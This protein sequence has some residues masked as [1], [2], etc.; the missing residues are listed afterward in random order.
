MST[1]YCSA[2]PCRIIAR[3]GS[4]R[5]AHLEGWRDFRD[6][7]TKRSTR[8]HLVSADEC[9][10]AARRAMFD[11]TPGVLLLS[12]TLLG[13]GHEYV[14]IEDVRALAIVEPTPPAPLGVFHLITLSRAAGD[15]APFILTVQSPC[16]VLGFTVFSRQLETVPTLHVA[17]AGVVEVEPI[18]GVLPGGV[19]RS[20]RVPSRP[21][22]A[23]GRD[24]QIVWPQDGR[25]LTA[26]VYV[27][28]AP[29]APSEV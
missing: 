7:K 29:Q 3:D 28:L 6:A 1:V 15:T 14:R 18:A 27:E 26:V 23:V 2:T 25:T 16:A 21:A 8:L 22:V 20:Y 4:I 10:A 5:T 19:S 24:V 9:A 12:S 13:D 11:G 17:G